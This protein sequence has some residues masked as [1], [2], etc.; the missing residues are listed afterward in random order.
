MIDSCS[1]TCDRLGYLIDSILGILSLLWLISWSFL[2]S[3]P[4]LALPEVVT[5]A[6]EVPGGD[7]NAAAAGGDATSRPLGARRSAVPFCLRSFIRRSTLLSPL[8]LVCPSSSKMIVSTLPSLVTTIRWEIIVF[9][10]YFQCPKGV[11]HHSK[12]GSKFRNESVSYH[13]EF[14]LRRGVYHIEVYWSINTNLKLRKTYLNA[15]T[16]FITID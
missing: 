2:G 5:V 1:K 15:T 4:F 12:A 6:V 8:E 7:D 16:N 13:S 14:L 10:V 9:F 3:S 11:C